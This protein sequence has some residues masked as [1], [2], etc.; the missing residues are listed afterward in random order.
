MV[1]KGS[2]IRAEAPVD[3]ASPRRLEAE[4]AKAVAGRLLAMIPMH[5][6]RMF[7]RQAANS[8][9]ALGT[10]HSMG[11]KVTEAAGPAD[12][13]RSPRKKGGE[14]STAELLMQ[15]DMNFKDTLDGM[16]ARMESAGMSHTFSHAYASLLEVVSADS[17]RAME[18]HGQP[19]E[20]AQL[21][22][23]TNAT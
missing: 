18:S 3:G 19:P 2:G 9:W 7:P 1:P 13:R 10:L 17:F 23:G 20:A 4:R 14:Q 6:G 15:N 11:I 12:R 5:T 16:V 22:K 8:I 21:L